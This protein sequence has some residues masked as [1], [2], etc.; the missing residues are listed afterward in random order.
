LSLFFPQLSQVS[1]PM[2]Q[3]QQVV[4]YSDN[5]HVSEAAFEAGCRGCCDLQY[6]SNE[7]GGLRTLLE[8]INNYPTETTR[9][10]SIVYSR[11][12]N[13]SPAFPVS[14][15][16][17]RR[18][19]SGRSASRD[20][21]APSS[22]GAEFS[23]D[24]RSVMPRRPAKVTQADIARAIRA[25]KAAGANAVTVDGEGVIRIALTA[26]AAPIK[27]T[28][29]PDEIWVP[30]QASQRYRKRTESG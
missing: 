1:I 3:L 16:V 6:A 28:S 5:Q 30:S 9:R 23:H 25:A 14:V 21:Q 20:G 18:Q 13:T 11:R 19:L 8:E 27:P 10:P 7:A 17:A 22:N 15:L 26:S 29:N 12:G 24:W 2:I 4:A